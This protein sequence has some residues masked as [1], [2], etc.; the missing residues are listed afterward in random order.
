MRN[1]F[2]VVVVV[3]MVGLALIFFA[4]SCSS[5]KS[6]NKNAP[7]AKGA[8]Q[9]G[10]IPAAPAKAVFSK[11]MGG[12]T[13][14]LK[15][16]DGKPQYVRV[17]AF[18]DDGRNSSVYITSFGSERMQE[19]APGAYDIELDTLPPKIYKN[20][21]ISE[22][23]EAV[24][25]F[26]AMTGSINI[27]ALNSKKKDAS[28]TARLLRAKSNILVAVAMANKPSEII[29]GTY[30]LE[31]DTLPRQTKNDVRIE[32][33]KQTV[34]DL[35]VVSGSVVAKAV[36]ENGKEA[37][38]GVRIKNPANG[39]IVTTTVTNRALEIAPGEYDIEVMATPAQ[40]KK[41]VKIAAG[42]ETA[43]EFSVTAPAQASAASKRK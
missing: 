26:G 24:Q 8:K 15:S 25:D 22:G 35:G 1:K 17:K 5:G 12:L 36:D 4:R 34:I 20:I 10:A 29:P 9:K 37:R 23:K 27:K 31:I 28:L 19:L 3:A 40:T 32:P 18:G 11:G 30:N 39:S 42:E 38:L 14:R 43:L 16:S 6:V 2:V 13:V 7:A 21:N 41:G 33:G